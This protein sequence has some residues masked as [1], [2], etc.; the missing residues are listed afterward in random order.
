MFMVRSLIFDNPDSP[1]QAALL[2]AV[3]PTRGKLAVGIPRK[4]EHDLHIGRPLLR[5]KAERAAS[6]HK[7]R[8]PQYSEPP[9]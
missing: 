2:I 1:S 4:E 8:E 9:R 3:S 6:Q 7:Q 5:E